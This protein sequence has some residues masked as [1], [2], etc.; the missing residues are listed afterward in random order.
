MESIFLVCIGMLVFILGSLLLK[1]N[2]STSD[3]IIIVWS[4][5]AILS[6]LGFYYVATGEY[7]EHLRFAQFVF[8][9]LLL[10]APL[11]YFYVRIQLDSSFVFS[12]KDLFHLTPLLIF[13]LLHIPEFSQNVGISICSKH[14]GCYLSNKPCSI[15]YN[16]S[17][18]MLNSFYLMLSFFTYRDLNKPIEKRNGREKVNFLWVKI[19]LFVA[20]SLNVFIIA[21]RLLEVGQIHIFPANI[22]VLNIVASLYI[23]VFSFIGSNF[24]GLLDFIKLVRKIGVFVRLK[25]SYQLNIDQFEDDYIPELDECHN[26]F[27]L[28]EIAIK[29]YIEVINKLMEE[30]KPFLDQHITRAKFSELTSIPSHHLAY[31]IKDKFD[32]TFTDFVNSWRL[33][34]LLEKLD[35]TK[36]ENYT[37]L[38]LAFE[39]GFNSKSTFNRYFKTDLGMTPTEFLKMKQENVEIE[40]AR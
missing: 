32:Q 19:L 13:Y 12:Y 31:V 4:V 6:Q 20:F 1:S 7:K 23:I 2:K 34:L 36:Y 22:F 18:I 27:G 14:F 26:A 25:L 5:L 35:E 38:A 28:S 16:F 17:K 3:H 40:L 9:T 15:V 10:H 21:Y 11:L 8:G 37:L 39:C 24:T 29:D 33:D 30:K